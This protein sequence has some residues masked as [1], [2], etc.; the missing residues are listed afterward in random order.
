MLYPPSRAGRTALGWVLLMRNRRLTRV[1]VLQLSYRP[2]GEQFWV[3]TS[4]TPVRGMG[5]ISNHVWV[6]T[7]ITEHKVLGR[8]HKLKLL[9]KAILSFAERCLSGLLQEQQLSLELRDRAL[10]FMIEGIW[11]SD[12]G[13]SLLYANQGFAAIS[14]YPVHEVVGQFWHFNKVWLPTHHTGPHVVHGIYR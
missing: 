2:N 7:D 4:V 5:R 1:D 9:A 14:G 8:F 6:H 11:I 3:Q 10:D 13:G 12:L